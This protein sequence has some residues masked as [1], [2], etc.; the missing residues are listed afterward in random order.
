L[1]SAAI[2]VRAQAFYPLYESRLRAAGAGLSVS[3]IMRDEDRHLQEMAT[4]LQAG[5]PDW[6]PRL[7]RVL[8][9]EASAFAGFLTALE[10]AATSADNLDDPVVL[11]VR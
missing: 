11:A 10:A 4:R 1:T 6:R 5:L 8:D 2:E 7:E 3:A 9:Q